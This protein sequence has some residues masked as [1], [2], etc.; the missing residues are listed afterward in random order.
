MRIDALRITLLVVSLQLFVPQQATCLACLRLSSVMATAAASVASDSCSSPSKRHR[1]A[2]PSDSPGGSSDASGVGNSQPFAFAQHGPY[3]QASYGSHF[4]EGEPGQVF[5]A[6][7]F[8][9][10]ED[11]MAR[12]SPAASGV[13]VCAVCLLDLN[14][15][16]DCSEVLTLETCT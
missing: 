4:D 8:L 10:E 14:V 5:T 3:S 12:R 9:S 16:S 7:S 2:T 1:G 11:T 15:D 6:P 13:S